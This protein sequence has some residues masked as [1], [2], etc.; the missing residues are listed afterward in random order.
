MKCDIHAWEVVENSK[1]KNAVKMQYSLRHGVRCNLVT[2]IIESIG[3]SVI[4]VFV[5]DEERGFNIAT[6]RIDTSI[7]HILI[8]LNIGLCDGSIKGEVDKL[9]CLNE[10][11]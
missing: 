10:K 11:I 3:K 1:Q 2:S 7:K 6:V 4:V 5:V 9:S 8:V